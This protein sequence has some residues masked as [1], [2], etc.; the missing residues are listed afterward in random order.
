MQNIHIGPF[1]PP[2]G[3]ISV[4][5]YRLSK[6]ERNS[7]F[8]DIKQFKNHKKFR[9]W[10]IKQIFS[11]KKKNFI[12]HS[13]SLNFRLYFFILSYLSIHSFS[14]V[15]HGISLINQYE[16]SNGFLKFM[17]KQMLNKAK[18]IQVINPDYK[19]FIRNIG[20]KNK[21]IIVKNAFLPPPA[22]EEST[23][24]KSYENELKKF[25]ENKH[26]ILVANAYS[27][28][29]YNNTDLYGLD[30]CVDLVKLL[31]KDYPELGF[32]FALADEKGNISYL[33]KM[34]EKITNLKINYNFYF[35]TGHKELWPIF[36]RVDLMIR[37]TFI[38]GYG[39]SVAEALYFNCPAIASNVCQ[40]PEGTILFK[41]RD[42]EDLYEKCKNI[43]NKIIN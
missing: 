33:T 24:I 34:K 28:V 13:H 25:L 43:L 2:V 21:S 41:N 18:F 38:D 14:L 5:L 39:V 7:H 37:P 4:Y 36:K 27:L 29:F 16:Q 23:I 12:Y 35:M 22:E 20:V 9:I 19:K 11:F 10:I 30:L 42:L 8:I 6:I 17:I 1:P 26:P 40:R 15:I 3:G 32:I 31:K